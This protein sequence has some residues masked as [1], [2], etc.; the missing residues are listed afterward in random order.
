MNPS[1]SAA[2]R[3]SKSRTRGPIY[4]QD[5]E[6]AQ[7]NV[8]GLAFSSSTPIMVDVLDRSGNADALA[9]KYHP[10]VLRRARRRRFNRLLRLN[11]K[12]ANAV[13]LGLLSAAL[14]GL[15]FT[16]EREVLEMSV[17]RSWSFLVPASIALL[18]SFVHG[19]FTGA[20]WDAVGM[21]P[22]TVRK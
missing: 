7:D 18:F 3:V 4:V 5:T 12:I 16:Y 17:G 8:R 22:N 14:Y 6:P 13:S 10:S 21:K 15:L 9:R 19:G 1:A 11:P 20:F 2:K